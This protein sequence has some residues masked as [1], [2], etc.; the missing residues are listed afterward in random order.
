MRR[1]LIKRF[2]INAVSR[3]NFLNGFRLSCSFFSAL[4]FFYF[5][6]AFFISFP[7]EESKEN[8]GQLLWE[9]FDT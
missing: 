2:S 5:Q 9:Q 3:S 7:T 8:I 1:I 4:H 6:M